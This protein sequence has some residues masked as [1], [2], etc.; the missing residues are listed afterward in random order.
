MLKVLPLCYWRGF[1]QLYTT[2]T[3]RVELLEKNHTS[4]WTA[5]DFFFFSRPDRIFGIVWACLVHW[6]LHIFWNSSGIKIMLFLGKKYHHNCYLLLIATSSLIIQFALFLF[7]FIKYF[8]IKFKK[9]NHFPFSHSLYKHNFLQE[10]NKKKKKRRKKIS[11]RNNLLRFFYLL[12][13]SFYIQKTAA[14]EKRGQKVETS[15][16]M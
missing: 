1:S 7:W 15:M 4:I 3:R 5:L 6:L 10:L 16:L 9:K 14:V 13:Q 12:F 8:L 2:G 11:L